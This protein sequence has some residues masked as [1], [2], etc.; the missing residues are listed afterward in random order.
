MKKKLIR[1]GLVLVVLLILGVVAAAFFLGSIVTKGVN[2]VG[3]TITKVETK[4]DGASISMLSGKGELKGLFL[5][6]PEGFK[7][8]SAIKVCSVSMAIKAGSSLSAEIVIHSINVQAPQITFEG[9][10][11]GNNLSKI[12]E[13]IQAC[14]AGATS[15][16][17]SA[18]KTGTDGGKKIQVDDFEITGGKI[19]LSMTMLGGKALTVPLPNIHLKN[20]GTDSSGITPAELA[21][22]VFKELS[23]GA[24]KAATEAVAN[25]GKGATD[26]VKNVGKSTG[27]T[28]EKTTKGIGDMFKKK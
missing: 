4:L 16:A 28:L 10:L 8:P 5:G 15:S 13:S 1:V 2:T 23:P 27:A 17:E 9:S 19:N 7:T 25:L 11:S 26:A 22:K 21:E 6:N 20:L 3:P 18:K 24:T 12:L 14:A